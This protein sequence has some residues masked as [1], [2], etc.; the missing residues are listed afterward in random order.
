M[1]F[2]LT[3]Y[4]DEQMLQKHRD[5]KVIRRHRHDGYTFAKLLGVFQDL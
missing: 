3:E 5:L 4:T 1:I 2:S